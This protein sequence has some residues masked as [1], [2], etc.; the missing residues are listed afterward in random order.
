[1]SPFSDPQKNKEKAIKCFNDLADF[2][3][4]LDPVKLITQLT[5]THLFY[6]GG[7]FKPE[8]DDIHK[9]SRWIEFLSGYLLTHQY[10]ENANKF[11]DGRTL[12]KLEKILE[13][14]FKA[15]NIYLISETSNNR[16]PDGQQLLFHSKIHSLNVR[17][18]TF[19]HKLLELSHSLYSAHPTLFQEKFGLRINHAIH[20]YKSIFNELEN[21]INKNRTIFR[22]RAKIETNEQIKENPE[23]EGNR[24]DIELSNFG[25]LFFLNSDIHL[26]FT[27]QEL[28]EFSKLS[29]EIC[30]AF[31]SR[32]S[33]VFGYRNSYYPNTYTDPL[34]APWDYNTLYEKPIVKVHSKFF[35]PNPALF[36]TVLLNTFHYD[37]ITDDNFKNEYNS[38]RGKWLEKRTADS[39]SSIFGS[40]NVILN[41]EYPSGEELSDVLVLYDRKIFIIQCKSKALRYESKIGKDYETLKSDIRK[42]IRESFDQAIKARRY[43]VETENPKLINHNIRLTIDTDQVTDVFL[44]S[45]TLGYYQSIVTKLAN[46]ETELNLFQ[47]NDFPWAISLSDFETIAEIITD[48][49]EFIHYTKQRIKIEQTNFHLSADEID[50]LNYYL[51]QGINF[52][53]GNLKKY[54][55]VMLTG[56]SSQVEEYFHNKYSLNKKVVKP[57]RDFYGCFREYLDEMG[58]LNIA[59]KSDCV[60]KLLLLNKESQKAFVDMVDETKNGILKAKRIKAMNMLFSLYDFGITFLVMDSKLDINNLYQQIFSYSVLRKYDQQL[61]TWVGLGAH[62]NSSKKVDMAVYISYLWIKDPEIEKMIELSKFGNII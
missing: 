25:K 2:L 57:Q 9:W 61:T 34:K 27:L 47:E 59:Y 14:Y 53:S 48:P 18:D 8:H 28:I 20:L 29:P 17:G 39:L 21:R 15:I 62:I 4:E 52:E 38:L 31:L 1:M 50:L 16:K 22:Q 42:G 33:Q 36:P 55:G 32:L 6:P 19:P 44:I 35:V 41:P 49:S 13:R 23:L 60:D 58:S 40:D 51:S 37:L 54:N 5:L 10:P 43:L 11:I 7:E 45:I 56:F 26:S 46:F 24:N 12:S 30:I 3:E